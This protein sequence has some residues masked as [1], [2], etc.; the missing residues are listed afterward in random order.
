VECNLTLLGF[1]TLQCEVSD[2]GIGI[3]SEHFNQLFK[4][5]GMIEDSAQINRSGIYQSTIVLIQFM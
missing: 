2:T 4:T 5:F 3:K 1:N